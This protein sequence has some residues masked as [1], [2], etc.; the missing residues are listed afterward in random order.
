MT[1][2]A[3]RNTLRSEAPVVA[4]EAAAGCGKTFEASSLAVD[5]ARSLAKGQEVLLLAHT[6]AAINVFRQRVPHGHRV[7][8]MT[9]D[10]FANELAEPYAA[11]LGLPIPLRVGRTGGLAFDRLAPALCDL[12]RRAPAVRDAVARHY[13]VIL[14]D[15][16]QD[17]RLAQHE[18]A[19]ELARGGS[20]VRFFGDPMQRIFAFGT[21]AAADWNVIV[22]DADEVAR[23]ATPRRWPFAPRL[24]EWLS[25]AREEL[26]GGSRLPPFV[27]EVH[28]ETTDE[29]EP[30]PQS[31]VS[32]AAV[33][34]RVFRLLDTL[35]GS[36]GLLVRTRAHAVGLRRA[37]QRRVSLFE[38]RSALERAG[39]LVEGALAVSGR[40]R[41]LAQLAISAVRDVSAGVTKALADQIGRCLE[42]DRIE[43]RRQGK[44]LPVLQVLARLYA[45]PSASTWCAVVGSLAEQPPPSVNLD[46]AGALFLLGRLN[47]GRDNEILDR[48]AELGHALSHRRPRGRCIITVHMAKGDEFEHVIVPHF[49]ASNFPA[50]DDGRKLLYVALTRACRSVYLLAPRESPSPLGPASLK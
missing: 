29:R 24:G 6:H 36:V 28:L 40:P 23:L 46:D 38:G 49:G 1:V 42:T 4:V 5:L 44:L 43:T 50:S 35:Q 15:E 10:S 19:L 31:N 25:H 34:R 8:V 3:C 37:L 39:N 9:L 21:A 2:E 18:A 26:V 48:L 32:P 16:H 14:L 27:P 7:R 41:E 45:D 20:R 22:R 11:G 30:H 12:L 47:A 17:A 13:P 33:A